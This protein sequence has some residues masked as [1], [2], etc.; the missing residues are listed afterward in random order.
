MGNLRAVRQRAGVCHAWLLISSAYKLKQQVPVSAHCCKHS[1]AAAN[2]RVLAGRRAIAVRRAILGRVVC[3]EQA[4]PE[5]QRRQQ[6]VPDVDV[7]H[8]E[9]EDAGAWDAAELQVQADDALRS[10]KVAVEPGKGSRRSVSGREEK[11]E[12]CRER[13]NRHQWQGQASGLPATKQEHVVV[14]CLAT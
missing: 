13:R 14:M 10:R 3:R 8:C 9:I 4:A 12:Q 1:L 11:L 7:L 2:G 6:V 5:V